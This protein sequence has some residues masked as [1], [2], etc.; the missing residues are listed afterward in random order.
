MPIHFNIK[1][2]NPVTELKLTRENYINNKIKG[3]IPG[4][5]GLV[6]SEAWYSEKIKRALEN[7][8]LNMKFFSKLDKNA[9]QNELNKFLTLNK[10]FIEVFDLN[11]Y[12]NQPGYYLMVLD[13][14]CQIYVG[15]TKH[16][17]QRVLQHWSR[18]MP[19]DRLIFGKVEDSILAFDSFKAFDTTR[20]FAYPTSDTYVDENVYI[21]QF[22]NK[23]VSNRTTGGLHT[24][25]FYGAVSK[26]RT[27]T[28]K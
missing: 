21:E 3:T 11:L 25:G 28:L 14:Y 19:L 23:F 12:S 16:I 26:G 18:K 9:F 4:A 20:I 13:E 5:E 24:N 17:K 6:Y 22:S 2:R 8:D 1:L 27:K 15:T 7:F 10:N